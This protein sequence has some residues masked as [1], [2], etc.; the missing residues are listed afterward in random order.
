MNKR[1]DHLFSPTDWLRLFMAAL[2][3]LPI[4][5]VI[6][7]SGYYLAATLLRGENKKN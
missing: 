7:E 6:R 4:V 1:G 3:I 5:T 2:F